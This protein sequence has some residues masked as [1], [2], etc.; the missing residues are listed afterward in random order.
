MTT[1]GWPSNR[2]IF[3]DYSRRA[4]ALRL[5]EIWW[6][7]RLLGLLG[8][9]LGVSFLLFGRLTGWHMP[10]PGYSVMGGQV[11]DSLLMGARWVGNIPELLSPCLW[12]ILF[13]GG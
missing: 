6:G 9:L 5:G 4:S 1:T 3:P 2:H 7:R 11:G 8:G 10:G 12:R 13:F